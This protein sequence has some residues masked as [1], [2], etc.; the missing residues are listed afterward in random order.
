MKSDFDQGVIFLSINCA[1]AAK[2]VFRMDALVGLQEEMTRWINISVLQARWLKAQI[3][4]WLQN[5]PSSWRIN[6]CQ[7]RCPM[8]RLKS[9]EFSE[10]HFQWSS[11]RVGFCLVFVEPSFYGKRC[12]T[13]SKS[14]WIPCGI[15]M[16]RCSLVTKIG[17]LCMN[18]CPHLSNV[19]SSNFHWRLSLTYGDSEFACLKK[20]FN[21]LSWRL[22]SRSHRVCGWNSN[23]K[24]GQRS[25]IRVLAEATR[26]HQI[27]L[28]ILGLNWPYEKRQ[29]IWE[30]HRPRCVRF[31]SDD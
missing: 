4:G 30:D 11:L 3:K 21:V 16:A 2:V 7:R 26:L 25:P 28:D 27:Y 22:G 19:T 10:R 15:L 12:W 14:K 13:E 24:K 5:S 29:A 31:S 20:Q 8:G 23:R 9:A 1:N 17:Q 18:G 6:V